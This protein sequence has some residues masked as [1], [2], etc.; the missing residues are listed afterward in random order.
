[1]SGISQN[2]TVGKIKKLINTLSP[3][4]HCHRNMTLCHIFRQIKERVDNSSHVL[5]LT[6]LKII[7]GNADIRLNNLPVGRILPCC[8]THMLLFGISPVN[9]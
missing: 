8:E 9:Y 5:Q 2:G 4:L 7:F 3:V 1:M 6:L